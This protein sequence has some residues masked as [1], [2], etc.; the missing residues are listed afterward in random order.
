M[1]TVADRIASRQELRILDVTYKLA[2]ERAQLLWRL[3]E[4]AITKHDEFVQSVIARETATEE[5]LM[6]QESLIHVIRSHRAAYDQAVAEQQAAY[7]QLRA[8]R[9][10]ATKALCLGVRRACGAQS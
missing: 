1:Q 3:L 6:Q 2:F 7:E 10:S 8:K 4:C 5:E 9:P